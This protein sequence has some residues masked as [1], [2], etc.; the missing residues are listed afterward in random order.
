[1]NYST[2]SN[3]QTVNATASYT[4]IYASSTTYKVNMTFIGSGQNVTSTVWILKNGTVL[5]LDQSGDNFSSSVSNALIL[6]YFTGFTVEAE[7]ASQL[8]LYTSSSFFHSNGTSSVT[9]GSTAFTVTNYAAN[10]L[11]ET[12]TPCGGASETLTAYSLSVGKPTGS[13]V[14]LVTSM[15]LAETQGSGDQAQ[16]IGYTIQLTSVTIAS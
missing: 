11:P 5:A 3:G 2:S 16:N 1:M 10:S 8:S 15:H 12:L 7:A 6:D 9:I 4:T 14:P 13:N